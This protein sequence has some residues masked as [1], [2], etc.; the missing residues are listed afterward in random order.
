MRLLFIFMDGVGLG[1]DDPQV[2]PFVRARLPN[3]DHLLEGRK[4][5]AN[6][7]RNNT[8]MGSRELH[9][10]RLSMLP[11][12]ARLGINGV[13]QS[14]SG[15]ASLLTGKNIPVMLGVHDGPKPSVKIK[16]ILKQGTI[17]SSLKDQNHATAL[18]NAYPE[19]YFASIESGHRLPGVIAQAALYAGM[20]LKTTEDLY[21]GEA[22]SVDL[23]G[24]GWREQL[25]LPETPILDPP[26]AGERLKLLAAQNELSFFEFWLTDVM[27][28]HQEM[29][30][31]CSLLE[32]FDTA[33]GA[34]LNQ[35]DD[36]EGLIL[37]TSDHGNIEDLS[38]RHHTLNDVPLLLIGSPRLRE[39]FIGKVNEARGARE[40]WDLSDLAPAVL[41]FVNS[42]R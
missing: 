8:E 30:A 2:N 4:I 41:A 24:H 18:I 42:A 23:T 1:R 17:F 22:I 39:K 26:Q 11:L 16:Q 14:A 29:D 38:T 19:R 13:P 40:Q 31:A 33:L 32:V 10:S 3:L 34:L 9:T 20:H 37:I 6:G 15:Q 7:Y 12:D 35:W 5:V 36:D 25:S 27:G 28:H 21:R